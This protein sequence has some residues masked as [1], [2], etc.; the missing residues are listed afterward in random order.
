MR[1]QIK[2]LAVAS[3]VVIAGLAIAPALYG[4]ESKESDSSMMEP[5]ARGQ[6][7]MMGRMS[8]MMEGCSRMMQAMRQ[9]DSGRPNEQWRESAP[10]EQE[11]QERA[12]EPAA[13]A[14]S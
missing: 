12:A 2:V 7:G 8:E 14:P 9:G 11:R 10:D 3:A 5:D 6:G 1:K 13:G 4:Q